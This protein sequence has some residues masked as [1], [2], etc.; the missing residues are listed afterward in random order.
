[1]MVPA[2]MSVMWDVIG[3]QWSPDLNVSVLDALNTSMID[4]RQNSMN[5]I[6]TILS[7]LNNFFSKSIFMSDYSFFT[8]FLNCSPLSS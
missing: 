1:M 7:P 4:I 2:I 3:L 6:H 5:I 8:Q